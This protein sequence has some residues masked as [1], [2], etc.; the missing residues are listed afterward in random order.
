MTDGTVVWTEW[1]QEGVWTWPLGSGPIG[2]TPIDYDVDTDNDGVP[3]AR[4]MDFGFPLMQD[5]NGNQFVALGAVKIIDA[6]SLFNLNVHGNRAATAQLPVSTNFANGTT[7][8][9]GIPSFLSQSDHG[10][11]ASEVNP[12]W[13]LNARPVAGSADF[14][15]GTLSAALQQYVLFFRPGG[16]GGNPTNNFDNSTPPVSYELA[17]M[18]MW[19]LL[20]GRPQ[21]STGPAVSGSSFA[22]RWGENLSRLDPQVTAIIGGA[23]LSPV[24]PSRPILSPSPE[25]RALTTTAIRWKGEASPT[26]RRYITRPSCSRSISSRPAPGSTRPFRRGNAACFTPTKPPRPSPAMSSSRNTS[27]SGLTRRHRAAC[28]R[29]CS[30]RTS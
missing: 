13:A 25:R 5:S 27:S 4:Y 3:D 21:L 7:G 11:S 20:N 30:G 2:G 24:S 9:S 12:E 16:S 26:T 18:E 22:G 15:G 23:T 14:P 8:M 28:T 19:N 1:T 29:A 6:D 10:V 17:N